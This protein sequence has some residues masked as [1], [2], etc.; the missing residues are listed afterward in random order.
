VVEIVAAEAEIVA[1][2]V[3]IGIDVVVVVAEFPSLCRFPPE[4]RR[5]APQ[6]R[7]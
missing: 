2:A 5:Q 6:G 1:V 3:V 7:G 4:W